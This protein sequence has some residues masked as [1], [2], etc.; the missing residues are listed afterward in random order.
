MQ[1]DD[2]ER[3][4]IH[5][6]FKLEP[7]SELSYTAGDALGI[8]P[9]NNPPEV[10]T[11][12][13]AMGQPTGDNSVPVPKMAYEP[14]PEKEMPL[15][16]ALLRFYDLKTIQPSLI[17]LIKERTTDAAEKARVEDLLLNGGASTSKNKAL[18]EYIELRE[19]A[20]VLEEFSSTIKQSKISVTDVLANMKI[21][22]PRYYSISSSPIIGTASL[23]LVHH[24]LRMLT[25]HSI[26]DKTVVSV[27]A[28]VVRYETLGKPRTGVTTTFLCDRLDVKQRCPVFVNK[29]PEF[30]YWLT[31]PANSCLCSLAETGMQVARGWCE[32]YHHDRP[33]HRHCA[34]PCLYPRAHRYECCGHQSALLWLPP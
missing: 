7:E 15:K 2:E 23:F 3:R 12:L 8:Y 6:E 9:L 16:E 14:K 18:K 26:A 5:C 4:V 30:R 32:G 31:L 17:S 11:L 20:D 28:A 27:T 10:A 29:N 22:Q 13:N 34:V 24:L 25:A 19:V 33:W 21:L 1:E